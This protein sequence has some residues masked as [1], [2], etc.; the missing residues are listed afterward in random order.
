M[1]YILISSIIGA[2]FSIIKCVLKYDEPFKYD[3]KESVIVFASSLI[4]LYAYNN[5]VM[6]EIKPKI[7]E[8]FTDPPSF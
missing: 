1:N 4:G 5:F 7:S 2:I 6:P 8:V 3:L